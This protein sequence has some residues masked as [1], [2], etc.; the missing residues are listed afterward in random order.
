MAGTSTR[1]EIWFEKNEK[2]IFSLGWYHQ[3]GL[4]ILLARPFG[5]PRK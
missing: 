5:L 4:K 1:F 2:T 3:P